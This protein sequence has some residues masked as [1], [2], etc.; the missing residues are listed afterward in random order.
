MSRPKRKKAHEKEPNLERWLV[1]YADFITLLFAVFVMLYAMSIVDQ[2]KMEE[3]QASIQSSFSGPQTL[4]PALKV[5]GNKDFGLIPE[6]VEPP[7]PPQ[8]Q[9][10]VSSAAEAQEFSQI[11]QDIQNNLQEYGGKNEVQLTV[12]ERGLVISLKEAGFFPSGTAQVQPGA[13]PLLDKI[14]TSISRYANTLRIEG[15]TDNVP[16]KSPT[17]PSNWELSTARAN[18]IVHYLMEKHG[19]M[20]AKLS[21]TGYGEYRPIADNATEE[22][23]KLNRRVDIVMLSRKG[24]QGEALKFGGQ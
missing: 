12:N 20:G 21:V 16:V 4:T 6:V 11:K 13:L 7:V 14:A 22:G 2:K 19:F 18:S 10:E 3:V 23:R 15:H 9:E 24:A 17:F 8:S 1:S 5:I